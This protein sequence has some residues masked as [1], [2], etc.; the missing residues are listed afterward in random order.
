MGALV[1]ALGTG[2]KAVLYAGV[3]PAPG[4]AAGSA[5]GQVL[6]ADVPGTVVAGTLVLAPGPVA[7]ALLPGAPTWARVFSGSGEWLFDCDARMGAAPNT[8]QELVIGS[9]SV[10]APGVAIQILSGAFTAEAA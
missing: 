2:A 10:L 4:A 9:G 5:V 7:V 1:Q 3:R 8:G 6:F